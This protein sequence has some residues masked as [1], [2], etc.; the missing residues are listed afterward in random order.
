ME[1]AL[2]VLGADTTYASQLDAVGRE[3]FGPRWLGVHAQDVLAPVT[4]DGVGV[5][6]TGKAEWLDAPQRRCESRAV[7]ALAVVRSEHRLAWPRSIAL[8]H[9]FHHLFQAPRNLGVG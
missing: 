4:R 5:A 2:T 7:V 1:A 6:N 3:W 9:T 8:A